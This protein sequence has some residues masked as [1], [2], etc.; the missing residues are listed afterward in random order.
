[1]RK[2]SSDNTP[3]K[4]LLAVN[5]CRVSGEYDEREASLDSQREANERAARNAGAIVVDT[6][7]EK[8]TGKELWE[9]PALTEVREMLRT[10]KANTVVVY[11]LD[12]FSRSQ[13]HVAILYGEIQRAGGKLISATEGAFE[14]TPI[15]QLILSVYAFKARAEL[16]SIK[17]RVMRGKARKINTGA[18]TGGGGDRFG[19]RFLRE[20]TKEKKNK[21]T[22]RRVIHDEE[23]ETVRSIFKM[24]ASGDSATTVANHLNALGIPTRSE[25]IGRK[26]LSTAGIKT[27]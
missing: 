2:S 15:G 5:Y 19:Y 12:R 4:Q 6:E 23:A 27:L 3:T 9:R 1:M 26:T 16:E 13:E 25:G 18:F 14:D 22:G 21:N 7:V 17:D 8:H 20:D 10:G 24:I 11:A